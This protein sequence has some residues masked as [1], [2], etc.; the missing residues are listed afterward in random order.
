MYGKLFKS[1]YEGTLG[2]DWQA[3]ITFQQ[4]II[5]CDPD[6]VL[7]MTHEALH[8]V[9]GIPLDIICAGIAQLEAPDP[10]SRTPDCDGRRIVRLD[11]HRDWGWQI[12]NHDKYKTLVDT[13][14]KRQRN[15]D[16]QAR[17]RAS[18]STGIV[19]PSYATVTQNNAVSRHTD[20]DTDVLT[21]LAQKCAP[22]FDD[23]W[24]AYP[25]KRGKQNAKAIWRR[26]NFDKQADL[27]I[28]DVVSRTTSDPQWL[29][30]GGEFIPYPATYL[31]GARWEDEASCASVSDEVDGAI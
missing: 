31:G 2:N 12:V 5:L 7:D 4:M 24:D 30:A 29:K 10:K 20:T 28:E 1:M 9:T 27:I 13:E 3:L 26:R 18:R 16:R 25:K 19:T 22:R 21:T 6:G 8:R 23:F 15:A 17:F 11:D 14:T